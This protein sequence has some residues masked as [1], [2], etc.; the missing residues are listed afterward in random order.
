MH[1]VVILSLS[2]AHLFWTTRAAT[3]QAS[4]YTSSDCSGDALVVYVDVSSDYCFDGA[5]GNSIGDIFY[6]PSVA[7]GAALRTWSGNNC[8]GSSANLPAASSSN[9]GC[10]SIP[11]ASVEL[12][13]QYN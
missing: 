2:L 7:A 1:F 9:G 6:D 3:A 5:G 12:V 10:T 4:I 13:V 8:E 11:F